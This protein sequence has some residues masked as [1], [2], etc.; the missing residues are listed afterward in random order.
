MLLILNADIGD[1]K[2]ESWALLPNLILT[3][4]FPLLSTS[5]VDKEGQLGGAT[6]E[7]ICKTRWTPDV[8][9]VGSVTW[10]LFCHSLPCVKGRHKKATLL[11]WKVIYLNKMKVA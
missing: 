7:K 8:D 1:S 5:H 9:A 6:W 3:L 4:L 10:F 11:L 2:V